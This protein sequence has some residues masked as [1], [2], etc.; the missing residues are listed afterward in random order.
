MLLLAGSNSLDGRS[1]Y[2][3]KHT[4][5]ENFQLV[6]SATKA[7]DGDMFTIQLLHMTG[8]NKKNASGLV[9]R[10]VDAYHL[11]QCEQPASG[12]F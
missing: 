9:Q 4:M 7:S 5:S 1:K 12:T 11:P 6:R 2:F 3:V 10:L 8:T